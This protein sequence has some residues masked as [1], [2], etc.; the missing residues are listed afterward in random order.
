[1]TID[2]TWNIVVHS[3]LGARESKFELAAEG[4]ELSGHGI[5]PEGP[6]PIM[7]GSV[8]GDEASWKID[9]KSPMPVTLEFN[10]KVDGDK[11]AGTTKA[12]MFG[13]FPFEGTRD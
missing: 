1:M 3:P 10:G 2:G 9:V 4:N 8:N 7:E 5:G 6:S 11:I 13:A 12:G